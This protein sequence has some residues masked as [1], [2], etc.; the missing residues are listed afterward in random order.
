MMRRLKS[1]CVGHTLPLF[2]PQVPFE[3]LC[4]SP[5]GIANELV[6][7]DGRFGPSVDGGSL[8]EY[9]QLFGLHEQLSSGDI[10]ADDLF[11]FQYRKFISPIYGGAESVSPWIR[12]LTAETVPGIFPSSSELDTFTTRLAVGSIFDFGESV[13]AN[14][15]RV[16]VIE[17]LV[18]FAAACA[19]SGVL[20]PAD[21]KSFVTLRGVIPSPAVCFIQAELFVKIMAVLRKVWDCYYPHYHV[22][23][24]G[25][26]RRVSGYLFERLH[27]SLLCQWLLDGSEPDVK[28]WNRYV[29]ADVEKAV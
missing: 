6:I 27:S 5:L 17:D 28:L 25:Y 24:S 10:V 9:S 11:L 20:D 15:A 3:M 1:Y 12:V 13:S 14:Y 7:D 16:H 26:Q 4:P 8:A 23:R 19:D 22:Q 18:M 2:E 29:V 21:I